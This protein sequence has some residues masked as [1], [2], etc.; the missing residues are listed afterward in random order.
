MSDPGLRLSSHFLCSTRAINF[1]VLIV[2]MPLLCECITVCT[3]VHTVLSRR[4]VAPAEKEKNARIKRGPGIEVKKIQDKK[5]KGKVKYTER[6]F[7]EAQQKT[8]K[9][10]DWLLPTEGGLLE[11]DGESLAVVFRCSE[12]KVMLMTSSDQSL[13][14][15]L[16]DVYPCVVC[17]K[18]W[19]LS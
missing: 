14:T 19:S 10:N 9:I 2:S 4:R 13:T 12:I 3:F 7:L 17:A 8:I 11:A 1:A 16:C 6:V 15:G 18:L 5:L